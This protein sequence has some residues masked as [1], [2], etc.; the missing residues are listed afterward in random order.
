MSVTGASRILFEIG[1]SCGRSV[2]AGSSD[3]PQISMQRVVL[4]EGKNALRI[5]AL[6]KYIVKNA[7]SYHIVDGVDEVGFLHGDERPRCAE[8]PAAD[9][10]RFGSVGVAT[11]LAVAGA[12][13]IA[14]GLAWNSHAKHDPANRESLLTL[15]NPRVQATVVAV[16]G[17]YV[18][19]A[20]VVGWMRRRYR[21]SGWSTAAVAVGVGSLLTGMI[22]V[23]TDED[24]DPGGPKFIVNSA[25]HGLITSGI[26]VGVLAATYLLSRGGR[27]SAPA[28]SVSPHHVH[29][30]WSR[31]F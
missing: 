29:V 10:P 17:A 16:A 31:E 20:G 15:A 26:S 2:V 13:A 9:A 25:K 24:A 28:I 1:T 22:L 27:A 19:G 23:A 7:V 3:E 4:G 14:G 5:D 8:Q 6:A 11:A 30:G 21:M 12:A 18:A